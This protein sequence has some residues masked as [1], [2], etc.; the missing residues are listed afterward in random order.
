MYTQLPY[1]TT[2][3]F[4]EKLDPQDI[5]I[6]KRFLTGNGWCHYGGQEVPR[7][8]GDKLESPRGPGGATQFKSKGLRTRN[9]KGRRRQIPQLKPSGKTSQILPSTKALSG[10]DSIPTPMGR[11]NCYFGSTDSLLIAFRNTL[12]PYPEIMFSQISGHPT[13]Q[14]S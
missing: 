11:A 8:T 1:L 14:L 12:P 10:S 3:T 13:I 7:P 6:R 2:H 4:L 9:T 5:C